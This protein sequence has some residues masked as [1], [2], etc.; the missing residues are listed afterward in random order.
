MMN[1]CSKQNFIKIFRTIKFLLIFSGVLWSFS[2]CKHHKSGKD[3]IDHPQQGTIRICVDESFEPIISQQIMVFEA[4]YSDAHIIVKYEPEADCFRDFQN[5]STRMMIVARGLTEDESEY[6]NSVLGHRPNY[7]V[8][9]FDAVSVVVNAS[10]RDSVF[11]LS[12]LRKILTDTVPGNIQA[13]L[14][15]ENAT[16]TVRYLMDSVTKGKPFGTNV[17]GVKGSKAVLDAVAE[18]ENAI[19]FIGSSWFG[20]KN[21]SEQTTYAQKVHLAY[22]ESKKENNSIIRDT[23]VYAK[24]SQAT[25]YS[26]QY[27]LIRTLYCVLKDNY[28]GVGTS[29]YNFMSYQR[30]Q[31]IFRVGNLV[32]AK[33]NFTIRTVNNDTGS[34]NKK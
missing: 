19:G 7:S 26:E 15:G 24:P 16:S 30:G 6:Y 9:A 22:V 3:I 23:V 31:L 11:S 5:D 8:M 34:I 17:R 12:Q 20:N 32:P 29:F 18:N 13:I 14:D 10:A 4:S 33:M 27:P 25:I 28:I 1:Y 21:D 2:S